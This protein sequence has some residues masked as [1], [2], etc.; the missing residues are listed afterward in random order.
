[1]RN[2][3]MNLALL[4]TMIVISTAFLSLPSYAEEGGLVVG[5]IYDLE[6]GLPIENA[7]ITVYDVNESFDENRDYKWQAGVTGKNGIYQV[8]F[9][10]AKAN[11]KG[12]FAS[13]ITTTLLTDKVK[14]HIEIA[15]YSP[16]DLELDGYA[17]TRV[18]S[19][20]EMNKGK[21]GIFGGF[22]MPSKEEMNW[23]FS[24]RL[25]IPSIRIDDTGKCSVATFD[26]M[27]KFNE[28]TCDPI[29]NIASDGAY[30]YFKPVIPPALSEKHLRIKYI[31]YAV[32]KDEQKKQKPQLFECNDSG[33]KGDKQKEDG[34]YTGLIKIKNFDESEWQFALLCVHEANLIINSGFYS[35]G[36]NVSSQTIGWFFGNTSDSVVKEDYAIEQ[37]QK[38]IFGIPIYVSAST[39]ETSE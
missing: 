1:M 10:W 38:L 12:I 37:G 33:K 26:E 22:D 39:E 23:A 2:K 35:P 32:K 31:V 20:E 5:E 30:L 34:I 19:Q 7:K 21:G 15:K 3:F 8:E 11:V 16:I 27:F 28:L 9:P 24:M 18:R 36:D 17:F 4:C 25:F 14:I 29:Q 6:S 13:N